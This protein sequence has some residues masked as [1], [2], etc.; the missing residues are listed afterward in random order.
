MGG[1][2]HHVLSHLTTVVKMNLDLKKGLFDVWC[3]IIE[4]KTPYLNWGEGKQ[5]LREF[6]SLLPLGM[7]LFNGDQLSDEEHTAEKRTKELTKDL[8]KKCKERRG[9]QDAKI[10][11]MNDDLERWTGEKEQ[12]RRSLDEVVKDLKQAKED[13]EQDKLEATKDA[14]ERKI[15]QKKDQ[16][17]EKRTSLQEA[18]NNLTDDIREKE[19]VMFDS[20][21]ILVAFLRD[22]CSSCI[23]TCTGK[24][25]EKQVDQ[26]VHIAGGDCMKVMSNLA[27]ITEE[28][29]TMTVPD[30]DLLVRCSMAKVMDQ[31]QALWFS[32]E[33]PPKKRLALA[34]GNGDGS[35]SKRLKGSC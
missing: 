13:H 24:L 26:L 1:L 5:K 15:D 32:E 11:Q 2:P 23:L 25:W 30:K 16:I 14:L 35:H 22:V 27:K 29:T 33:R 7:F 28:T 31:S 4:L 12:F 19:T 6:A 10:K 18:T 8:M 17:E 3:D 20:V 9:S 34:A 21:P